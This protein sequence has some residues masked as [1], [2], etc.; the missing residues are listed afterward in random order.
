[1]KISWGIK[2]I[3]MYGLFSAGI[4]LMVF[5]SMGKN[6]DLVS[7]NYYEKEIKYQN[8]IDIL[9]KS[10]EINN[11]IETVLNG[12]EILINYNDSELKGRISGE[13]VFYRPSDAK[14]DFKVEINPGVNGIQSVASDNLDKGQWKI[15]FDIM[16]NNEKY[17]AEK[18]IFIN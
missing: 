2:V 15:R 3:V 4:L 18:T 16:Q 17:F 14:K 7:E 9:R 12:N 5:V 10:A 6:V 8:Q 1:M 11:K 13:I